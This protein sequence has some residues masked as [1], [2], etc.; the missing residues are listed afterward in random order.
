[1]TSALKRKV[2]REAGY[3]YGTLYDSLTFIMYKKVKPTLY[4]PP[5]FFSE[6]GTRAMAPIDC[7][8]RGT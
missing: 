7:I 8:R 6:Q 2:S 1:L 5:V 4:G 3:M